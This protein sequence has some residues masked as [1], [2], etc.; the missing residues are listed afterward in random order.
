MPG[1][2]RISSRSATLASRRQASNCRDARPKKNSAFN[3]PDVVTANWLRGRWAHRLP[4]VEAEHASVGRARHRMQR[5]GEPDDPFV[6][7][8]PLMRALVPDGEPVFPSFDQENRLIAKSD[9]YRSP[10]GEIGLERH[11][12][13]VGHPPSQPSA[14][15][16]LD[17]SWGSRRHR[18]GTSKLRGRDQID[19][20]SPRRRRRSRSRG[21]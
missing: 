10:I 13:P 18:A 6:E 8:S 12:D 9:A 16:R 15:C 2:D 11:L 3:D 17:P 14:P 4:V 1:L 7:C 5:A 19:A 20:Y 21:R